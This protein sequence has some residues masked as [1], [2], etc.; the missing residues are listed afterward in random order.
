MGPWGDPRSHRS[1]DTEFQG[2]GDLARRRG[3][4]V[5]NRTL[6]LY[7]LRPLRMVHATVGI[8]ACASPVQRHGRPGSHGPADRSKVWRNWLTKG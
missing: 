5:L 4:R 3:F 6:T 8:R 2:E 1:G 7:E